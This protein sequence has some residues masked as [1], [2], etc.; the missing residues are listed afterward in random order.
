MSHSTLSRDGD[1]RFASMP[2]DSGCA[3]RFVG[4][5]E[6]PDRIALEVEPV[7]FP[8]AGYI[9]ERGSVGPQDRLVAASA[10]LAVATAAKNLGVEPV[11]PLDA[12]IRQLQP[13]RRE[14]VGFIH[15]VGREQHVCFLPKG[16]R[17]PNLPTNRVPVRTAIF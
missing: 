5:D 13:Y 11:L 8:P 3:L 7:S 9:A 6:L 1:D 4:G 10:C 17:G 14:D 2:R 16:L 12:R 15:R